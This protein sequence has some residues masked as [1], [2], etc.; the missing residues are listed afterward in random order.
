MVDKDAQV[1]TGTL[2]VCVNIPEGATLRYT[3]DGV[4]PTLNKGKV[5]QTGIFN[6]S[7]TTC[8]RLR[9]F[10]DGYLPS[11]VVTRSYIEDN[12]NYPF[13]IISIVTEDDH[14]NS[15]EYGVFQKGPNG[16]PG[17]GQSDKCNWNMDWDRPV[18]FEYITTD[19]ECVISQECDLATCG[20]WS[21][22][23]EPHSFKLKA[24][25]T[26]DLNNF[27]Q[28]QLFEEKPFIK[29]KTL[30]I[31]NGGNDNWARMK[32]AGIQQIVARSGFNVDY[33]AWQPVHVFF[34]GNHY[35]VLNMREPNNKHYAYANYGIDTDEMDQFEISP[36]SGYRQMEGTDESFLRLVELSETADQD[37]TYEEISQLL[38]IDEYIN[39]MAVELYTG[40]WDW[41]QNNVKGFRDVNDGKFRF[42]LFDLDGA[43]STSEPFK[44]F[45]DKQMY[46]FDALK[47]Y[48][49]SI[50]KNVNGTRRY[51][52]IKFVTLFKN[53]LKNKTFRKKFIDTFCI[54]GGS[55]FQPSH[56]SEI[57]DDMNEYLSSGGY[58]SPSGTASNIKSTLT[59]SY[60]SNMMNQLKSCSDMLLSSTERQA[61]SISSNT[62]G[63]KIMVND[64]ELPYS[65]FE[66]YLYAPI[67]IKATAP[68]GYKF[69]GWTETETT[70]RETIFDFGS[71]WKYYDEGSLD[72]ANWTSRFYSD[73][74][75][76]SGVTP[77]GYGKNQ[78]TSTAS[79]L[80]CYYFRRSFTLDKAPAA[81]DEFI[82][83]FSID[84]GM[85]LYINGNEA[86]R[87]NMPSGDIS[88]DSFASTHAPGNPDSGSMI[89]SG[90]LFKKGINVIA[91]EI[92]NNQLSSSDI[93]WDASLSTTKQKEINENEYISTDS[94]Y[95]LPT[96]G[97][98]KL[99]A[100]FEEITKEEMLAEGITPIRINEVSA[101]NSMYINDYFKK[102]DWIELHNTTAEDIDIAGMYISDNAD[103]PQKYQVPSD[104]TALNT[105]IPA[106]G[107]KVIWCDKLENIGAD[108]HTSFKL[109]AEGGDVLITTEDYAD[110]LTYAPHSGTQTFGRYPDGA[111]DT[112]VMNAPTI[113]K[114]NMICSYDTVFIAPVNPEP[115]SI[116]SYI[117][118]GGIAIA[119]ADGALNVKSEEA[120]IKSVAIY[121]VTGTRMP[122]KAIMRNGDRFATVSLEALP[123]GIYMA[124]AATKDGDE[125][126]IK[127]AIK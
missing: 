43:F 5:S 48:D 58:V 71:T 114:S 118:E 37:N 67:T 75:W 82:L 119:Y 22:A 110:T 98:Q 11:P 28:A 94:E 76:Q 50:G 60:N 92:H 32:D 25:K 86:G 41:P 72:A 89:L 61:F 35:A 31:R 49:Y 13:P 78:P 14:L 30:Q 27:F 74:K 112:Y 126:H 122:A 59:K 108:I 96:S 68:A 115:N 99:I 105:I 3:T 52:E 97:S 42:V 124:K 113:A 46:T 66:G 4:A 109:A 127:F 45:F 90:S 106:N 51:L 20:G 47:G 116:R 57:I 54:V 38:N 16:R 95:T 120:P 121:S 33:Q 26:Y 36:D 23:W 103:K 10:K 62:I 40:N 70:T 84:D 85:V 83:D 21:R 79:N 24:N 7:S 73:T 55:I 111:N 91:V 81:N 125:C 100:V 17:N 65:E 101:A 107:F 80:S 104:N 123:K 2:Q 15:S 1:F 29:N 117:K 69:I 64:I 93:V 63:S 56:V 12:G 19:N 34:N 44:T 87:Y 53:M 8:L 9:L 88:Y 39:Y 6:I 77:I 18:S 102:N